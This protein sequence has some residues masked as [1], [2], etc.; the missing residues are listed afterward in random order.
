METEQ[1]KFE[2]VEFVLKDGNKVRY[3][4]PFMIDSDHQAKFTLRRDGESEGPWM[5][6]HPDDIPA[7][8]GDVRDN[9]VRLGV[10]AN[11]CLMG[12]PW[13]G[14]FPYVMGG[15]NRPICDMDA[16][17]DLDTAPQLY[18]PLFERSAESMLKDGRGDADDRAYIIS[19]LGAEH[20][21]SKKLAAV[22]APEAPAP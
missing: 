16:L 22:D 1:V 3:E 15:S 18:K 8:K 17:I 10:A 7:Y 5:W 21:L 11:M 2:P 6:I 14:V 19:V 12:V 20:P 4:T 9:K 13:G